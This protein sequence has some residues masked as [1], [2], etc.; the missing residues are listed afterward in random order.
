MILLALPKQHN[1]QFRPVEKSRQQPLRAYFPNIYTVILSNFFSNYPCLST[2]AI[3]EYIL[4][5]AIIDFQYFIELS[6][7]VQANQLK[8]LPM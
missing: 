5:W 2:S 8:F 6:K 7:C 3:L 4:E 1:K